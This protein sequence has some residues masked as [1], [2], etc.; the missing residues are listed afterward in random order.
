MSAEEIVPA[1]AAEWR[2]WLERNH[3]R[4]DEVWLV[5]L[6]QATSRPTITWPEAVVE[7]IRHGWIDGLRRNIDDERH[8]QR[9]TPRRPRSKWSKINRDTA[10]RLI[11]AGEMTE[12]GLAAVEAGKASGE[13]DRAYT[14]QPP[15]PIPPDLKV[16]LKA[17]AE[18]K[19]QQRRLNRTRWDRWLAWLAAATPAQRPRRI[20]LIVQALEARDNALVDAKAQRAR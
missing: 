4:A 2:A 20:R 8:M 12:A 16:A 19:A 15:T 1:S 7:A 9:F 10:L 14:V 3:R 6:K 13:W 17:S 11:A 5:Y 18:A